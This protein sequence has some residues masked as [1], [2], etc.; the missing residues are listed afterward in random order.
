M[1]IYTFREI[2]RRETIA[3]VLRGLFLGQLL[4]DKLDICI[5]KTLCALVNVAEKLQ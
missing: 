2:Y 5:L 1:F 3:V 4:P